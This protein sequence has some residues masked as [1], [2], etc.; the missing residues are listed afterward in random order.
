MKITKANRL[1]IL[2]AVLVIIDQIIKV[3]V[4]TNMD[5]GE[6]IDVIG[7]WFKLHFVLNKGMAFGM[8]FGGR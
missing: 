4:K 1:F 5:L 7:D 6:T 3:L 2:G 8:A